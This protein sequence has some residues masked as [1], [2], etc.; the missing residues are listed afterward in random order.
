[1]YDIWESTPSI[2]IFFSILQKLIIFFHRNLFSWLAMKNIFRGDLFSLLETKSFFHGTYFRGFSEN[3]TNTA[4][5]P[6][7]KYLDF[8]DSIFLFINSYSLVFKI[9]IFIGFW[10]FLL[11]VYFEFTKGSFTS[12]VR[13]IFRKTYISL[14]LNM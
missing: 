2:N 1:M 12:G 6:P 13:K 9:Y 4:K 8:K 3:P 5:I 7:I 10:R 11:A 14:P